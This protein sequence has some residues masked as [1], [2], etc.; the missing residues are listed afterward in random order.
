MSARFTVARQG[1]RWYVVY[2]PT[3][4]TVVSANSAVYA[5]TLARRMN[6]ALG[7]AR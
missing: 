2:G 3:G 5:A 1:D 4:R 6:I 7:G